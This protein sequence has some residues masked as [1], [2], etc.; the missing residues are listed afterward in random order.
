MRLGFCDSRIA[1]SNATSEGYTKRHL[2][3]ASVV[4][5]SLVGTSQCACIQTDDYR[6]IMRSEIDTDNTEQLQ[7]VII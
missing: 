6:L 1:K 7:I 3:V 4:R 5:I 2:P